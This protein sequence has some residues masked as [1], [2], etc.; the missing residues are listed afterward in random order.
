MT[1][2]SSEEKNQVSYWKIVL[3][4]F[5]LLCFVALGFV[6]KEKYFGI[7]FTDTYKA[8]FMSNGQVYFGKV[9]DMDRKFMTL[10]DVYYLQVDN[11]NPA[12]LSEPKM[13]LIK[14]GTELHGPKNE[15]HINQSNILFYEDLRDDS[16]IIQSI[17]DN[18]SI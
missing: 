9:L 3:V 18:K 1:Y 17:K 14:L 12:N 13:K 7:K 15:M 5:V 2:I 4:L 8:V 10:S 16:K 11:Q 6:L